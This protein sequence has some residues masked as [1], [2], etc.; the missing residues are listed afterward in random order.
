MNG[1]S[2]QERF[3]DSPVLLREPSLFRAWLAFRDFQE[4]SGKRQGES[5]W[6]PKGSREGFSVMAGGSRFFFHLLAWKVTEGGTEP[7]G[8]E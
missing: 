5:W 1:I 7:T 3:Q 6:Q 4:G 8:P 2:R